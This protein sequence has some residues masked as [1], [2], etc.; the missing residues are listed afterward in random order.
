DRDDT[1]IRRMKSEVTRL[2]LAQS[3]DM[4]T[5]YV[6]TST[7]ESSPGKFRYGITGT[8]IRKKGGTGSSATKKELDARRTNALRYK[9]ILEDDVASVNEVVMAYRQH[10]SA[11]FPM[12][13]MRDDGGFK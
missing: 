3:S 6:D 2:K 13:G 8:I 4:G 1:E 12:Y 10:E 5:V 7:R 9:S 11:L